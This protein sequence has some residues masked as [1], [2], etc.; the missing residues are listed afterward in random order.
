MD[1]Y[2]N[3]LKLVEFTNPDGLMCDGDWIESKDQDPHGEVRLIQLADIGDG[4]F[5]NKS[6]RYLTYNKAKDL[7]CTFLNNGDILVARMCG[8]PIKLDTKTGIV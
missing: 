6:S 3:Y 1:N 4:F 7:N 8:G 5:L 2:W